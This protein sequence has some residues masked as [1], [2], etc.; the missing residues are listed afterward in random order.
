MRRTLAERL[1][2]PGLR[3]AALSRT[4]QVALGVL[5]I[6]V[7]ACLLAPWIVPRDPFLTTVPAQPPSAENWLGTDVIGRDV[8]EFNRSVQH[9][10]VGGSVAVRRIPRQ[11][12][13]SR[14][15]CGV[16]C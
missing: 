5:V 3:L 10:V 14:G 2:E 12:S 1:S 6:V 11:E 9:R 15:S 8:G 4:A 13:S 7:L 16:G